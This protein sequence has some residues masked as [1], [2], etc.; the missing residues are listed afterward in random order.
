M[1]C[2]HCGSRSVI[3]SSLLHTSLL[4]ESMHICQNALCGHT[5]SSY[6]EIVR[7]LSPSAM[8]DASINLPIA[9]E[10][11]IKRTARELESA[12]MEED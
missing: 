2:P 12:A 7:T 1:N 8:P 10:H 11:D 9:S 6:T 3:R 4:R 5:F